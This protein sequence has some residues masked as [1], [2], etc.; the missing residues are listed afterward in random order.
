MCFGCGSCNFTETINTFNCAH[1]G[2]KLNF[3]SFSLLSWTTGLT[4]EVLLQETFALLHT[5]RFFHL[6]ARRKSQFPLHLR[7]A[8][9]A[10]ISASV[11]G[12][13]RLI[14]AKGEQRVRAEA[15]L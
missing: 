5:G 13:Q 8:S 1:S 10:L 3:G 11:H 2:C 7:R 14:V 9:S 15:F 4:T 12:T 6:Q